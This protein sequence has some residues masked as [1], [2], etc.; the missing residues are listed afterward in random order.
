LSFG[1]E[2]VGRRHEDVVE[3]ELSSGRGRDAEL[4]LEL[5]DGKAGRLRV[6]DERRDALAAELEV[7]RREDDGEVRLAA[8]GDPVLGALELEAALDLGRGEPET[9]RVG[10]RARLGERE[11]AEL[12]SLRQRL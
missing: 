9:A 8:V 3:E 2:L 12:L 10:A 1:A 7:G 6:D 4:V 5:R 11:A